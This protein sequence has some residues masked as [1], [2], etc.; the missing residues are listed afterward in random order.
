[1]RLIGVITED[2]TFASVLGEQLSAQQMN[3]TR[4]S[5]ASGSDDDL[6]AVVVN[7]MG[8]DDVKA[9]ALVRQA[10]AYA[11]PVLAVFELSVRLPFR[12]RREALLAA[13]AADVIKVD[14]HERDLITRLQ[15]LCRLNEAPRVLIVDDEPP[16][17]DWAAEE[18][19]AIGMQVMTAGTLAEA[20]AAFRAGPIDALVVD[21]NLPDGDGISFIA[22]LRRGRIATPALLYTALN[23]IEDRVAGLE[24]AGADDYL[25]KPAHGDELRARVRV[26]LRP[27]QS[28]DQL[29][30]GPL[31]LSRKDR[32]VR[33][34][35]NRVEMRPRETDMLIYMAERS[36]LSIPQQMLYLDI[37]EKVY[38][39][40]GSNPVSAT[41]HRMLT[42]LRKYVEAQGE[43]LPEIIETASNC[44]TFWP[45]PLLELATASD[46]SSD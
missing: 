8:L 18:L 4:L 19:T 41:K 20:R 15:S 45:E 36:G 42:G 5:G 6:A 25:C 16:I 39:E 35:G 32:I 37:W 26:L 46:V 31:E 43:T 21:R 13:G 40:V 2:D 33:W 10:A 1:M 12:T 44:Y 14:D 29:I 27:R 34:R 28:D 30:F 9:D 11:A 24:Q 23:S 7:T 22:E 3:A 38:M 17:R